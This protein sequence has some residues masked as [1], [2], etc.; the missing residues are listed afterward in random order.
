MNLLR[1]GP[2]IVN[3]DNVMMVDLDLHDPESD[4]H[5][6]VMFEFMTR[7]FDKLDKNGANV[8]FQESRMFF[9]EEAVAIRNHLTKQITPILGDDNWVKSANED[10]QYPDG[11]CDCGDEEENEFDVDEDEDD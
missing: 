11:D 10:S 2:T 9:G 6:A 4:C 7:G 8:A 1:F 5:H 3:L